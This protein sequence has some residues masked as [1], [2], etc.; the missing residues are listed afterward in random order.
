MYIFYDRFSNNFGTF[1]TSQPE[2]QI[3]TLAE[4]IRVNR[5]ISSA[6]RRVATLGKPKV[7]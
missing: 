2:K 4:L 6:L 1:I 3:I 5:S 7:D